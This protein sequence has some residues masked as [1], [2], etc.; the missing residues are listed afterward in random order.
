MANSARV[1]LKGY[2]RQ[3][4]NGKH[5]LGCLL[6]MDLL[7]PCTILSKVMQSDDLDI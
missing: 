5:L 6:F 7:T 2:Y 3:Q 4:I 1:I